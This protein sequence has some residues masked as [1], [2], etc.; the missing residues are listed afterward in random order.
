MGLVTIIY[1]LRFETSLFV[2]SYDSQ[3]Y[4]GGIRPRLHTGFN[5]DPSC[6]RSYS[7]W[8]PQEKTSFPNNSSIVVDVSLLRLCI[9]TA[10]FRLFLTFS[11]LREC[12]YQIMLSNERLLGLRRSGFQASGHNIK[13]YKMTGTRSTQGKNKKHLQHFIRKKNP[14]PIGRFIFRCTGEDNNIRDLEG[15]IYYGAD[16]IRQAQGKFPWKWQISSQAD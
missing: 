6:L 2:A 13:R 8:R 15:I 4:G 3:G 7:I 10:A 5:S 14:S 9:E 11:L 12:V 16:W 1:C